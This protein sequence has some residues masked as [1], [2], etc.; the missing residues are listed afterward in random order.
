LEELV[1]L[2]EVVAVG[3]VGLDLNRNYSPPEVQETV[4]EKQVCLLRYIVICCK[5]LFCCGICNGQAHYS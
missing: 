2:P 3:E 5:I 4:F 1:Q